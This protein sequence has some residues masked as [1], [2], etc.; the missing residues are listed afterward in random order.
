MKFFITMVVCLGSFA[1][2]AAE[3][4]VCLHPDFERENLIF[5]P[6]PDGD[7]RWTH[8]KMGELDPLRMVVNN[9][10]MLTMATQDLNIMYSRFFHLDKFSGRMG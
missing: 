3:S 10:E 5:M 4:W 2:S 1:V 8:E 6:Q 9:D 7:V